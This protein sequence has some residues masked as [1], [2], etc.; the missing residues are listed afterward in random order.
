MRQIKKIIVHCSDTP[1]WMDNIRAI[2]IRGWHLDRGWRDIGYHKVICRDGS[3]EDGRPDEMVG[4]HV[5]GHNEDS[6]GVCWVGRN[7]IKPKQK[8][9]LLSQ[10]EEWMKK[11]NINLVYGH[12]ELNVHK[13]CPN[14][15]MHKLRE[16]L[17]E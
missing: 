9:S 4:A 12:C 16:E 7:E 1:D 10:I 13:T 2:D 3:I 17:Q 14:L 15:D 11:Y 6:L 8:S 5:R